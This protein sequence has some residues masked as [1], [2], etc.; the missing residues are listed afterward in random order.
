MNKLNPPRYCASSCRDKLVAFIEALYRIFKVGI[1]YPTGHAE[2]NGVLPID[3][4]EIA[5]LPPRQPLNQCRGHLCPNCCSGGC[6]IG[7]INNIIML[8]CKGMVNRKL[9][10][11]DHPRISTYGSEIMIWL[12]SISDPPVPTSFLLVL[13]TDFLFLE[14]SVSLA[15]L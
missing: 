15:L 14:E 10:F 5:E 2:K 3:G 8:L 12:T 11:S 9:Y 4:R 7:N 13:L 1:Y 6:M